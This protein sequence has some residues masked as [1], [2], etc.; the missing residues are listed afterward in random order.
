VGEGAAGKG[1]LGPDP[2]VAVS[3]AGIARIVRVGEVTALVGASGLD[4]GIPE[5]E[6]GIAGMG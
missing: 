1:A 6:V 3:D 2:A 4:S 5:C